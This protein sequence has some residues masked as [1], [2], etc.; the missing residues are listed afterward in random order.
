MAQSQQFLDDFQQKMDTLATVRRKLQAS[1]QFKQ[2]FTDELKTRLGGINAKVQQLTGLINDLKTKADNLQQQIGT[3]TSSVSDKEQE[4]ETIKQQMANTLAEKDRVTQEFEQYKTESQNRINTLNQNIDKSEA[5]LRDLTQQKEQTENQLKALQTD[6]QASGDQK[7]QAHAAQLTQIAQDNQKQLELQEQQL[8]QK[9]DECEAKVTD[10][11]AQLQAKTT[12]HQQTQQQ[13]AEHQNTSQGQVADL[14]RQIDN[15]T[16][17]NQGLVQRLIAATEAINEANNELA[18]IV[19]SVPNAQTKQEVDSLL[20]QITQQLEYSI[21]NISRA[22][23]G[24]PMTQPQAVPPGQQYDVDTNF[25]NLMAI[26]ANNTQTG[27]YTTFMRRIRNGRTVN[28]INQLINN[29]QKGD[30]AAIQQLKQ[31]LQQN[32]LIVPAQRAGKRKTMKKNRKQ[33]GGFTYKTNSKRK[34]ITSKTSR[35]SS[36][37]SSRKS[38]R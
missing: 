25:N 14:Q 2:Q 6:I 8:R 33:K 29:A 21:Q 34:S 18:T 16:R 11:Q 32:R 20:N 28:S 27:Q 4:I 9:I 1:V 22:A 5:Q 17:E 38:S 19:D 26:H 15:L 24:Q 3:N 10:L 30:Q 36:R 31:V 23:Q 35:R 37:T 7:D 13:L 12:E